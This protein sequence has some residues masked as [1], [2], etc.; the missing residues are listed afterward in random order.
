M[1]TM[2]MQK[3][4]LELGMRIEVQQRRPWLNKKWIHN[5]ETSYNDN[6]MTSCSEQRVFI[7]VILMNVCKYLKT[8]PHFY[9]HST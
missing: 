9:Q 6:E 8:T 3:Q 7:N 2:S 1:H 4:Q 5:K